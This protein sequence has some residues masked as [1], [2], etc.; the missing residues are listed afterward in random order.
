[1]AKYVDRK[2]GSRLQRSIRAHRNTLTVLDCVKLSSFLEALLMANPQRLHTV[3][4]HSL[5]V[6]R[7]DELLIPR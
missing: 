3:E 5:K 6:L 2:V 1:M 7:C 4:R